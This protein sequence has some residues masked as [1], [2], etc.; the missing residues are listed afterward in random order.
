MKRP[1]ILLTLAFAL[2]SVGLMA[3]TGST[4][5]EDQEQEEVKQSEDALRCDQSGGG[6]L[7]LERYCARTGRTM[8]CQLGGSCWCS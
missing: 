7:T 5:D 1:A 8:Y 4:I 6:C 2:A 3:C